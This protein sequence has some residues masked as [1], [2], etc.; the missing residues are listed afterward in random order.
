[1]LVLFKHRLLVS[2]GLLIGWIFLNGCAGEPEAAYVDFSDRMLVERPGAGNR[3][4]SYFKVAVG[5]I[6]SAQETVVHYHELLEYIAEKLGREIQLV[7]R[8]T[9]EEI[10]QLISAGQIDL[11]FI[12]SGPY[13]SGRDELGFEA[14]AM[15]RVRGS[16]LYQ[17][18]LIVNK[19]S[20]FHK[21]A[22]LRAKI[23]AF[24]DPQSNTGK[25]VP[26][27]WLRKEGEKPETFFGKTIYTYS[28]DNS[29]MAVAMSLVDGAAVNGQVW[30]YYN[31]RNPVFTSKTR[32]I[33]KSMPFG[34]PPVVA[35][36][37]LLDQ[38]KDRI[39]GL[40]TNMHREPEGKKILDEL[41]IDSFISPKEE[42]YDPILAMKE[43]M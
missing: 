36:S 23:F 35:S 26:D 14:L 22:D 17:S 38:M 39:R 12:C 28:H 3:D 25:L 24:S 6:I 10:N 31:Q 11:A 16:H 18:Y 29:I 7:Q 5:S 30:E 34:N 42:S 21:L 9:Y 43:N 33:K 41:M 37:H 2:A 15:P 8:K 27:Y 13:A 19:D 4:N 1:M 20:P 40:L 32:I